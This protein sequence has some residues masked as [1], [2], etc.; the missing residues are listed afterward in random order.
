SPDLAQTFAFLTAA[1]G[2]KL[3]LT[4]LDNLR[5]KET[6][7][8]SALKTELEKLGVLVFVDGNEM[9]VS[10]LISVNSAPVKT[11]NDHRMAMSAAVL[12]SV[13]PIEV[14]NPDVVAKSFPAFWQ[15]IAV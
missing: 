9:T 7:R 8:I 3:K 12:S 2:E 11:Y 15:Q 13:I 5:L 6:D 1:L 4:G 10:G 14:E